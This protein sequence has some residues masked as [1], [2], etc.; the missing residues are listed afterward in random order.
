M[1]T[2][3]MLTCT[4]VNDYN[5]CTLKSGKAGYVHIDA[6]KTQMLEPFG[7]HFLADLKPDTIT[8]DIYGLK[9]QKTHTMS[10]ELQGCTLTLSNGKVFEYERPCDIL[11]KK[12][13]GVK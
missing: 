11:I 9:G 4:I 13:K 6:N 3:L 10:K 12:L 8:E 2:I 7:Y 1:L 5:F